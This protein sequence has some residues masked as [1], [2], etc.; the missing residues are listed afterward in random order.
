MLDRSGDGEIF[1]PTPWTD[2][3]PEG[4][5]AAGQRQHDAAIGRQNGPP[6]GAF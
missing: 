4:W 2:S 3:V 5:N 1:R 6:I